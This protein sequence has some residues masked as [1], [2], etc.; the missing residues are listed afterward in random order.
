M[1]MSSKS[2]RKKIAQLSDYQLIRC[3]NNLLLKQGFGFMH[4]EMYV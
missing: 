3:V 1:K 2:W 4:I